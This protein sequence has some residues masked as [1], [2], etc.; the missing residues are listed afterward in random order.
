MPGSDSLRSLLISD[1][2][3]RTA[4]G[5]ARDEGLCV[6]TT[7]KWDRPT[8]TVSFWLGENDLEVLVR[9][10][11]NAWE[12]EICRT[13]YWFPAGGRVD[14]KTGLKKGKPWIGGASG[15]NTPPMR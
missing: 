2:S 7:F 6:I 3:D 11:E 10:G 14:L 13:D 5:R 9:D 4:R 12:G 15:A 8:G 1:A